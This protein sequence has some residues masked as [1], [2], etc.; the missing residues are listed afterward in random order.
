M[1][2]PDPDAVSLLKTGAFLATPWMKHMKFLH[3]AD[4]HLDSP[5]H[6][7]ER[8][9]G[10]PVSQIRGATRQALAR[11]VDLAIV[12]GVAFVLIAGDLYDG[13]WKDYNTG[14]F[15]SAQMGRLREAGIKVWVISGNHDASSQL[16]KALRPPDNVRFLSTHAP[17]TVH[18]DDLGVAI[19]G[20]GF[21]RRDVSEDLSARYPAAVSGCFNI[22]VLHTSAG[23]RPG[24][25]PYAPCT[26]EGLRAK[27]YGYWALGHIHTREIL[28]AS[29]FIVF[30][31]NIQGRHIR[32]TGSKGCTLV[33][34]QDGRAIAAEH[35]DT[36][37][38][39]WCAC[40]VDAADTADAEEVLDRVRQSLRA[41][42]DTSGGWPLAVRVSVFGACEAHRT[43]CADPERWTAEVRNVAA[44]TGEVW[45][46]K[47]KLETR[48]KHDLAALL[49]RDD[50]LARLV[51]AIHDLGATPEFPERLLGELD[52]LRRKL[53]A[54]LRQ[55]D[56]LRA[57]DDA[58]KRQQCLEDVRQLLLPRLL[59]IPEMEL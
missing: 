47:V 52:D 3:V 28:H 55:G 33:T 5:L 32:E 4:I 11:V 27:D 41:E 42:V 44:E 40:R 26:V 59:A 36:A 58:D 24:H 21:A 7:L 15:F 6:G 1:S 29:P 14:L 49:C 25:E 46:E 57:L 54:E 16:T 56:G 22:G 8:Y 17:E 53:P 13:D 12:E 38:L 48:Q 20:Q 50:P 45:I 39:R 9:E 23:G 31:G 34:V 51:R 35:R 37:V 30:P 19:H 43:L 10:A 18:L 2:A